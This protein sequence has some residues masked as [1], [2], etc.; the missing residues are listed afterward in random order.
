MSEN[1]TNQLFDTTMNMITTV[2]KFPIIRVDREEFLRKQFAKSPHLD[3]I[4]AEGPQSVYSLDELRKKA[5]EVIK[6]NTNKTAMVSFVS[7]LPSNPLTMAAAGGVDVAQYFGFALSMAQQLAYLFGESSLF[8]ADLSDISEDTKVR[9]VAYLGAMFG[10]AGASALI[11]NVSKR[12]GE[13]TGKRLV[14]QA[15][16]KTLWYP[17]FKKIA[18]ILGLKVSKKTVEKTVTKAIPLIGGVISGGLTYVSFKP[19]GNRLVDALIDAYAYDD[20]DEEVLINDIKAAT[21]DAEVIDAE[22]TEESS[23]P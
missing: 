10:A 11:S 20:K 16:T 2:S 8:E 18:R 17:L 4:L 5:Q 19:L 1:N 7:G 6:A 12:M 14:R 13:V 9:I 3:Q 21:A 23:A 22:F 15:L